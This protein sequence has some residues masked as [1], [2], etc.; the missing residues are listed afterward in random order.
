MRLNFKTWLIGLTFSFAALLPVFLIVFTDNSDPILYPIV[1]IFNFAA[2]C[3]IALW[4][5]HFRNAQNFLNKF[6]EA[7]DIKNDLRNPFQTLFYFLNRVGKKEDI[8]RFE[9]EISTNRNETALFV[10]INRLLSLCRKNLNVSS[11]EFTLFDTES[12][13]YHGCFLLG[14]PFNNEVLTNIKNGNNVLADILLCEEE[15]ALI[16]VAPITIAGVPAAVLRVKF[17]INVAITNY[18]W[19]LLDLVRLQCLR[20]LVEANFTNEIIRLREHTD[21]TIKTKSGFLAHLSHEVR[22]PLGIIL[23]AVE[24][25]LDGLC[26]D[27]N[28]DQNETLSMIKNNVSHLVDLMN[29][30][31]DFAKAD[32]GKITPYPEKILLNDIVTDMI[33]IAISFSKHKIIPH[34]FK[35]KLYV[36]FD[37]R[38][39]RQIL[40]N[41]VTNA[42]KYTPE[43]G[44]IEIWCEVNSNNQLV[45]IHLK[46]SGIGIP[47]NQR[48]K[49]FAPFERIDSDYVRNQKGTGIGLSLSQQLA[50][51]NKAKIDFVANEG[52]GSH[53]WLEAQPGSI[54]SLD[55]ISINSEFLYS[56][57]LFADG[58]KVLLVGD[59][60]DERNLVERFLNNNNYSVYSADSVAEA[61]EKTTIQQCDLIILDETVLDADSL[62]SQISDL[63]EKGANDKIP[64]LL[65]SGNAFKT[66][67]EEYL[68]AGA[69]LCMTKP[70]SF[71]ELSKACQSVLTNNSNPC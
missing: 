18:Q 19:H 23:N 5:S 69:D 48:D 27:I 21:K 39:L 20:T 22:G 32:A 34:E 24:L 30:V 49:V 41:L 64:I 12:G 3:L 15:D 37:R 28:E 65:I 46:D 56:S 61:K 17:T 71:T 10:N 42:I 7:Q 63:R 2:W 70:I 9:P 66:D 52:S 60:C 35:E 53:F 68:K 36:T 16:G 43:G 47:F 6:L 50:I 4:L 29:D 44:T 51:I 25:I 1:A 31:I 59:N 13:L 26:G 33:N 14:T 38:H 58:S 8:L 11:A 67:I 45:S 54:E 40:I 55:D 62:A 57:N